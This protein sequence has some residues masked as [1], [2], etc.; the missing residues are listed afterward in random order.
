MPTNDY[1]SSRRSNYAMPW[2]FILILA[3]LAILVPWR[4]PVRI[5]QLLSP[6]PISTGERA[7]LYASTIGFQ[8]LAAG[9]VFWRCAAHRYSGAQLGLA[10]EDSAATVTIGLA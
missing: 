3:A 9:I 5:R 7:A 4:G 2:D 1:I 10:L 6:P 8:W